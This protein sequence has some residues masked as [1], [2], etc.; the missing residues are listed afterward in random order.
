MSASQKHSRPLVFLTLLV[1]AKSFIALSNFIQKTS[2]LCM[3][4]RIVYKIWLNIEI[5]GNVGCICFCLSQSNVLYS[6][7]SRDA[8]AMFIFIFQSRLRLRREG[9]W[10]AISNTWH[11]FSIKLSCGHWIGQSNIL[12]I[13]MLWLKPFYCLFADT[14]ELS[15]KIAMHLIPSSFPALKKSI[16]TSSCF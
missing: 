16:P 11:I 15:S 8:S 2:S 3:R 7:T 5:R 9:V 4:K 12:Y 13:R 10:T 6:C 14:N 1:T